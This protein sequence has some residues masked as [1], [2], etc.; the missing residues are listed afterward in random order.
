MVK[1]AT[2]KGKMIA[3]HDSKQAT[4]SSSSPPRH[5]CGSKYRL[6]Y[7]AGGPRFHMP[8]AEREEEDCISSHNYRTRPCQ[9][10]VNLVSKPVVRT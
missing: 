10:I 2:V 3:R 6:T 8:N 5:Y 7:A 1:G 4:T 9:I